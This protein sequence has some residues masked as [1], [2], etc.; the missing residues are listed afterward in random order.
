MEEQALPIMEDK[1]KK[2]PFARAS[3]W[4]GVAT[5]VS[6]AFGIVPFLLLRAP[7]QSGGLV[8]L[9]ILGTLIVFA[10][11]VGLPVLLGGYLLQRR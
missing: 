2:G 10:L 1:K 3:K 9:T 5:L 8:F 6:S 11:F 4:A 7:G